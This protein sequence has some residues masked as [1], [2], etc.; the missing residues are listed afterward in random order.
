M[1]GLLP[2]RSAALHINNKQDRANQSLLRIRLTV[3]TSADRGPVMCASP[4]LSRKTPPS[5][6]SSNLNRF[7]CIEPILLVPKVRH[8]RATCG[9]GS[10]MAARFSFGFWGFGAGG[11]LPIWNGVG[12]F[13]TNPS[14]P[15]NAHFKYDVT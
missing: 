7:G 3:V 15:R 9:C 5:A 2:E 4:L 6:T 11:R 8:S 1:R 13:V 10:L 12:G 14:P